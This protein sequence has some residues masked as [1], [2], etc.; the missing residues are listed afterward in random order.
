MNFKKLFFSKKVEEKQNGLV[1]VASPIMI[2]SLE[3]IIE[4]REMIANKKKKKG[5]DLIKKYPRSVSILGSARFKEDNIY[6]QKAM[7]LGSK[8]STE[9][10]YA[11]VTG[12][13]PGIMEAA[14]RGAK[15]VGG[16][17]I[18]FNIKLDHEQTIN[19][20]VTEHVEFEY[21]FSR[22]TLLYFS[23]ESYVYFPGGFGTM[24]EFFEII[25]LVQTKKIPKV[26][27]ILVGREYW[28]PFLDL[29]KQ[30]MLVEN[31][32]INGDDMNIYQI[33]DDEDEI[34]EIIK[35]APYRQE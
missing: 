19:P 15:E 35:K 30:K 16:V 26:P 13:G 25:T 5:Y 10:K 17:S 1:E 34:I 33:V 24:D 22:K 14:N 28:T 29:I 3:K 23:A 20:Y 31:S 32:T 9:L 4:K 2:K 18:G 27:V 6:Y 11:V 21:F 12:G 7:R 8:I